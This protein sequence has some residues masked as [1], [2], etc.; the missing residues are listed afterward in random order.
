M[1]YHL[2]RIRHFRDELLAGR[3]IDPVVV[4]NRFPAGMHSMYAEPV[5]IDGNHRFAATVVA[6][7]PK[8]KVS[9]GGR[10]DVLR[11]LQGR[12][13]TYPE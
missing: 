3:T 12:R 2:G 4:D 10:I 1:T 7:I 11:W 9:Y 5:L 6:G 13:K 8:V